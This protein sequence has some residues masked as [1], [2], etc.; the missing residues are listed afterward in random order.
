VLWAEMTRIKNHLLNIGSHVMDVGAM[1]P[2]L[3]L[4]EPREDIMNFYERVSGRAHARQLFP[5]GR[6]HQDVPAGLLDD[7]GAWLDTGLMPIFNDAISLVA[8]NRIFKQRNVDISVGRKEDALA[9]GFSGPMIRA[10]G[11][12]W[13]IRKSQPYDVYDRWTSTCRSARAA[14]ATTG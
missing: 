14:I 10:A 9:W 1:T 5:P 8:D 11:I 12:P 13:D 3:W 6:R 4:F 2:N 7:I